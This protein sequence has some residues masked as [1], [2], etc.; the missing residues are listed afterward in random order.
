M[1]QNDFCRV[2]ANGVKPRQELVR[3]NAPVHLSRDTF[4]Y[5]DGNDAVYAIHRCPNCQPLWVKWLL[6]A[7]VRVVR[8]P[9]SKILAIDVSGEPK[10]GFIGEPNVV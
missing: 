1:L 7:Q 10:V 6:V 8:T 3:D 9:H 5:D 4:A 2:N